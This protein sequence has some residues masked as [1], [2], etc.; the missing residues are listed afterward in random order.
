[1]RRLLDAD[2]GVVKIFHHDDSTDLSYVQTWHDP[3]AIL[4]NN[5]RLRGMNDGYNK[6]RDFKRIASIPFGIIYQCL[7]KYGV[8]PRTWMQWSKH[9][10]AAFYKRIA[11]DPDYAHVRT[12]ETSGQNK[13]R[14][15]VRGA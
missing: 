11:F 12:S 8:E 3:T 1:M 10:R 15:Q 5:S 7:A 2:G 14:F 9:E 4:D 13:A 6:A